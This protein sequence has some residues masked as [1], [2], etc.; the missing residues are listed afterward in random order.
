MLRLVPPRARD[1]LGVLAPCFPNCEDTSELWP[2]VF[3][4]AE[5]LKDAESPQALQ[6]L[7]APFSAFVPT[8]S[9]EVQARWAALMS[10]GAGNG[11]GK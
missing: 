10:R 11:A 3:A 6:V 8:A 4:A 9:L 5:G 2:A 1:A 7:L